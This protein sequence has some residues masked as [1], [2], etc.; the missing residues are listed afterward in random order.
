MASDGDL[1]LAAFEAGRAAVFKVF[2][3]LPMA[4]SS[5]A[6]ASRTPS[7]EQRGHGQLTSP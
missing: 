3:E 2:G 5:G 6:S 1:L 7:D 4:P